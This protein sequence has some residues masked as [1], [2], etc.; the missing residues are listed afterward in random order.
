MDVQKA[1]YLIALAE[2]GGFGRAAKAVGLTQPAFSRSIQSLEQE[3][4]VPLVDRHGRRMQL[5]PAGELMVER[6]RRVLRELAEAHRALAA[7]VQGE[8][9]H[10]RLGVAPLPAARVLARFLRDTARARPGVRIEIER[11]STPE[12]VELLRAERI[13]VLVGDQRSVPLASD[14]HVERVGPWRAAFLV[15][16]GHPL[17]D[18]RTVALKRLRQWPIA[19]PALS[20][21][22]TRLALESL[23]AAID[24]VRDVTITTDDLGVLSELACESETVIVANP[25]ALRSRLESGALVQLDVA[26]AGTLGGT[27]VLVRLAWRTLPA[28]VEPL[29]RIGREKPARR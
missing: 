4:G 19:S 1:R 15:R 7:L 23:G 21:A 22:G 24:P 29:Y 5:T 27:T 8:T 16:A 11:R 13:D 14:L 26:G 10:V 20:P 17:L 9:G 2:H 18:G 25:D 12:L 28:A 6:G 3:L